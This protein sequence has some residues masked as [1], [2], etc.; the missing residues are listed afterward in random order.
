M[1]WI[2]VSFQV[3]FVGTSVITDITFERLCFFMHWSNVYFQVMFVRTSVVTDIT[4]KR[5]CFFMNWFNVF[6][7]V[8]FVQRTVIADITFKRLSS[9]M[10][11]SNL[12]F[13][14]RF[15]YIMMSNWGMLSKMF[16]FCKPFS[17]VI[18]VNYIRKFFCIKLFYK[19]IVMN[20]WN[21]L[22]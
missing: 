21:M 16:V 11:W 3:R 20:N 18:T 1:N 13:Q 19:I 14:V 6:F 17:T 4:F 2:N 5:L 8:L 22:D 7:Q 15:L 10:K 9:F 12:S